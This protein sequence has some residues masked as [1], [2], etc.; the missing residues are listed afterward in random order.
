MLRVPALGAAGLLPALVLARAVPPLGDG[1]SEPR[2]VVAASPAATAARTVTVGPQVVSVA[3]SARPPAM[4]VGPLFAASAGPTTAPPPAPPVTPASPAVDSG[5]QSAALTGE[6]S[7]YARM[8][9]GRPTASGE[10]YRGRALTAAHRS[11]PFGTRLRVTNLANGRSV[12]VRV[13]D[14]GPFHRRRILDLSRSAAE[15]LGM[16]RRGHAQVRVDVLAGA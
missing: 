6:A 10:V 12:E 2:A 7:Y 5:P 13:N 3:T 4:P 11:L 16:V 1:A 8:L 15:R 9:E 14:R